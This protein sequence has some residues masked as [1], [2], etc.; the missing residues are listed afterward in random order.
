MSAPLKIVSDADDLAD[1]CEDVHG[2]ECEEGELVQ[3]PADGLELLDMGDCVSI[4]YRMPDGYEYEHKFESP[5][6][7]FAWADGIIINTP[8]LATGIEDPS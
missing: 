8:V 1:L 5:V 7:M 6:S 4:V 3:L 2:E